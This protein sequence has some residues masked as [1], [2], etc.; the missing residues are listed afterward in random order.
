M[1]SQNSSIPSVLTIQDTIS[2]E[3]KNDGTMELNTGDIAII[4]DQWKEDAGGNLDGMWRGSSVEFFLPSIASSIYTN[5]ENL[6]GIPGGLSSSPN[7][8][9][10]S[11]NTGR[12]D[13]R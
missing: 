1:E 5:Y 8:W 2:V 6:T 10:R 12:T 4:Y 3:V 13:G 9:L 11:A 7:Y